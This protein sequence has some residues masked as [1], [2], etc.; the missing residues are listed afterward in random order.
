MSAG[1]Q[2]QPL[3]HPENFAQMSINPIDNAAASTNLRESELEKQGGHQSRS[4]S[5][6]R[7]QTSPKG[8]EDSRS[9]SVGIV[10]AGI[11]IDGKAYVLADRTCALSPA[12]WG[13]MAVNAYHEFK[14]DAIVAETNYGGAMVE[15]V[16]RA[17]DSSVPY[18]QVSA[19]RG[20]AVRAEPISALY[21]KDMVRHVGRFP[22]L[23]NQMENFS[24]A[25]Y[26]GD[27]SP[28]RSV[29]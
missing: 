19:A 27:K 2:R 21:E 22:E 14:A 28:D 10:V 7:S 17:A 8:R 26:M 5:R 29:H 9:D 13:R 4:R 1:S 3:A 23:E 18:I 11:G 15:A 25:G 12:G 24:T 16:I 6:A 20:K